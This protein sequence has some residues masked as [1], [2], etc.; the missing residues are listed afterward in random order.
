M[1]YERFCPSVGFST[2]PPVGALCVGLWGC[3][4]LPVGASPPRSVCLLWW[5]VVV[6]GALCPC[7]RCGHCLPLGC[8]L[9]AW[10]ILWALVRCAPPCPCASA[11]RSTLC[12]VVYGWRGC[13]KRRREGA[14]EGN[15][16]QGCHHWKILPV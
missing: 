2:S 6:C 12:A 13:A 16:P 8:A 4:S 11:P 7:V 1:R 14:G 3:A 15:P 10:C 5:S 9:C